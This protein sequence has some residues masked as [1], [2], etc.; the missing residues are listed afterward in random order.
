MDKYKIK[1]IGVAIRAKEL[2]NSWD[3]GGKDLYKRLSGTDNESVNTKQT[4]KGVGMSRSMD[5]P[6]KDRVEFYRRVT[7][8]VRH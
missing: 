4:R 8:M 2:L 7:I 6:I 3:R 5:Y 1:T